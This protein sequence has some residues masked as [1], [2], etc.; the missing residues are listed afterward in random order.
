MLTL[1][2]GLRQNRNHDLKRHRRTHLEMKP[3]KCQRCNKAFSRK[4]AVRLL[5]FLFLLLIYT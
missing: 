2:I 3:F 4:D 5:A 1:S